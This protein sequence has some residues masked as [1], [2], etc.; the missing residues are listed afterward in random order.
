MNNSCIKC[1]KEDTG[2][3][4]GKICNECNSKEKL[5]KKLQDLLENGEL[6]AHW[7]GQTTNIINISLDEHG[8]IVFD[9]DDF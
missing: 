9:V 8:N 6:K 3:V 7:E 2:L 4:N 1:G 5:I